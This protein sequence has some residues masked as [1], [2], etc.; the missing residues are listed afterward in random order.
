MVDIDKSFR[1]VQA[2]RRAQFE[3]KAGEV[4]ALMGENGAGK[5][6]LMK[7]LAAISQPTAG[8]IGLDLRQVVL[9]SPRG[10]ESW[11]RHHPLGHVVDHAV[12]MS[13]R[14]S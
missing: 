10:T 11:D 1:G 9:P 14:F 6:T 5:S 3:L 7:I 13:W 2:F 12:T 4:H 8:E